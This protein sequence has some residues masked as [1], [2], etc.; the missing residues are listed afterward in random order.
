MK[1]KKD[2]QA[3]KALRLLR[4]GLYLLAGETLTRDQVAAL[5]KVSQRTAQRDIAS[6]E[7]VIPLVVEGGGRGQGQ[8]VVRAAEPT[9]TAKRLIRGAK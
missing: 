7:Q 2:E 3:V 9:A 6:M 8:L 4:L 1:A 5:G